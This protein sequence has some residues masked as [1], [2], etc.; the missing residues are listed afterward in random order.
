MHTPTLSQVLTHILVR[1][2]LPQRSS[3][4][5]SLSSL[6]LSDTKVY[7]PYKHALLG[8][9]LHFC[10]ESV[11]GGSA[12]GSLRGGGGG[13]ATL[14]F[15]YFPFSHGGV[16]QFYEKSTCLTQLPLGCKVGHVTFKSLNHQNPRTPPCGCYIIRLSRRPHAP[17]RLSFFITLKPRVE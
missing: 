16:R 13:G 7:E 12:V 1:R 14:K 6:E 4:S 9:A 3:S 17:P 2:G 11:A 8:T 10:E 15:I 5:S